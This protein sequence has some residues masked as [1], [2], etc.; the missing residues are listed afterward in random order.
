ML[1]KLCPCIQ[2]LCNVCYP[3]TPSQESCLDRTKKRLFTVVGLNPESFLV[4]VFPASDN[5]DS[6]LELIAWMHNNIKPM[7]TQNPWAWAWVWAP[8]VGL[9]TMGHEV[10]PRP[11][12]QLLNL[13]WD[14][15]DL[16]QGKNVRVSVEFEVPKRHISRPTI[17]TDMD[18]FSIIVLSIGT[19]CEVK[20]KKIMNFME[21][22][23]RVITSY[24]IL[25]H[26]SGIKVLSRCHIVITNKREPK[27]VNL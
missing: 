21:G 11:C 2:K 1:F 25:S 26:T 8:N 20:T 23:V 19:I 12:D 17:S 14:H 7:P 22:C 16:H 4:N 24:Q 27:K 18:L 3:P 15:F 6:D 9:C 5:F 10:I 13:S